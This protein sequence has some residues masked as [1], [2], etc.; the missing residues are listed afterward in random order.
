MRIKSWKEWMSEVRRF[1]ME[2]WRRG[3][4]REGREEKREVEVGRRE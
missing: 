2:G 1:V 3:E 4:E